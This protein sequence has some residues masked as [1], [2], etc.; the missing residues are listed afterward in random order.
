M[1]SGESVGV[2][3]NGIA[4]VGSQRLGAVKLPEPKWSFACIT[5]SA[6]VDWAE[7]A[8]M[9][10]GFDERD[11]DAIRDITSRLDSLSGAVSARVRRAYERQTAIVRHE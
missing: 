10:E 6:L 1:T 4:E 11:F 3:D 7:R 8:V 9:D 5:R 2:R